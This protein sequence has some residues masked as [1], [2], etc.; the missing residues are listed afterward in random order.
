MTIGAIQVRIPFLSFNTDEG[1]KNDDTSIHL[2]PF[3]NMSHTHAV[4]RECFKGDKASQ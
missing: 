1:V 2:S 4:L 3:C